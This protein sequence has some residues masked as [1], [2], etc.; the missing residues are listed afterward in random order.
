MLRGEMEFI[1]M[2]RTRSPLKIFTGWAYKQ[3][4]DYRNSEHEEKSIKV[5]KFEKQNK[6]EKTEQSLSLLVL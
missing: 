1:E 6:D 5:I 3:I 4:K 2:K